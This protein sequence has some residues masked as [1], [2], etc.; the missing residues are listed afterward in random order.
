MKKEKEKPKKKAKVIPLRKLLKSKVLCREGLA[1]LLDM[2]KHEVLN[3]RNKKK[4]SE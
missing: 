2:E 3:G 4:L 1:C